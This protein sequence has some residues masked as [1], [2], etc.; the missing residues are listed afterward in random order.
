[1]GLLAPEPL[2]TGA[3]LTGQVGYLITGLKDV[4]AARVGDTW[5]Q[6]RQPVTPLP[7]FKP[8][9]PMVFAGL[10]PASSDEYEGLAAALERLCLNDASVSFRKETSA[11]LGAGFR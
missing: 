4:K 1:M 2:S 6:A 11:A 10:Y 7:G 9:R 5:H 8:I 3:L